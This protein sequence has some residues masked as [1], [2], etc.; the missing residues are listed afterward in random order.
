[1]TPNEIATD[2]TGLCSSSGGSITST[3]TGTNC[4]VGGSL[5]IDDWG[6][7]G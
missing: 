7:W 2:V 4:Y 1:M 5:T 3:V 6:N